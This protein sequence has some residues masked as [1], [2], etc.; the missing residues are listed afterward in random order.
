[1][2]PVTT[3]KLDSIKSNLANR[4]YYG[5][6]VAVHLMVALLLHGTFGNDVLC[7]RSS[8]PLAV[9][10]DLKTPEKV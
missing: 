5:Y 3:V 9:V 10:F 4:H 1:M 2:R 7:V 6:F 8:L